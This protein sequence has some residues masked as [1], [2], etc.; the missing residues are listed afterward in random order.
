MCYREVNMK[1]SLYLMLLGMICSIVLFG[2][3]KSEPK[4][5]V[6]GIGEAE[7]Q[8]EVPTVE[9]VVVEKYWTDAVSIYSNAGVYEIDKNNAGKLRWVGSFP[10]GM[11]VV[12]EMAKGSM[13][14]DDYLFTYEMNFSS[15]K[16]DAK[17][18]SNG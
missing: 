3:K 13:A 11:N 16:D 15:D 7:V 4:D 14:D 2:C 10:K 9:E 12:A 8:V 5:V 18:N 1:K 6:E 17:K